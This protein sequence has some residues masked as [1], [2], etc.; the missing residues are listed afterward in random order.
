MNSMD[1]DFGAV[2]QARQ[3]SAMEV[4]QE[5]GEL[6]GG[7]TSVDR[8]SETDSTIT[9]PTMEEMKTLRRVGEPINWQAMTVTF[10]EFC[11]RFSYYGTTAVFVN[12]IQ[13]PRPY[14]SRTGNIQ[15]NAACYRVLGENACV[16]PGGLDQDQRAATGL[17]VS[18]QRGFTNTFAIGGFADLFH[19]HSISFGHT[20]CL[21][22]AGTL[23]TLI[24][25]AT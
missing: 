6:A 13:Q 9:E 14:G 12:F 2:A 24:S 25:D 5:K 15:P 18:D 8:A 7:R 16:Q 21:W 20:S 22:W 17:T 10:V 3:P 23:P 4:Q 1:G 11:E 19:R